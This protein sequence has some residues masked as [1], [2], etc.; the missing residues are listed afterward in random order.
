MHSQYYWAGLIY[1]AAGL[2]TL[3]LFHWFG[4][5]R[6]KLSYAAYVFI[7]LFWFIIW[8]MATYTT[9][10]DIRRTRQNINRIKQELNKRK[11]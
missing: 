4:R 8:G 3:L 11:T 10:R 1:A 7:F 5:K 9:L 2:Y 6:Q